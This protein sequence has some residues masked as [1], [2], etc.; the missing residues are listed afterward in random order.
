MS[1]STRRKISH[2]FPL[3]DADVELQLAKEIDRLEL[4]ISRIK[5]HDQFFDEHS[6]HMYEEMLNSRRNILSAMRQNK[7]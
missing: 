4:Q 5:R 1:F 3:A 7:H 2:S 6:L